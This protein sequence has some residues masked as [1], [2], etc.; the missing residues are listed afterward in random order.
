MRPLTSEMVIA[1][2][3]ITASALVSAQTPD[4]RAPVPVAA[5]SEVLGAFRTHQVVAISDPHGNVQQHAFIVSLL[6]APNFPEVVDDIVIETASARYQD[7][8]DRFI[9]GDEVPRATLRRAWLDHTVVNNGIGDQ[10]A[11][12]LDTVRSVNASLPA[13][14]RLRV[15]AGDPPIDWSNITSKDDHRRWIELRDS[16]P[17]DLI[18]RQVI[19]RGHH[20]L[21]IYGQGHLQRRQ[22]ASNYDMSVW[23]EQTL[24]SLLEH[25]TGIHVFNVWTLFERGVALP[26][27]VATWPVPALAIVR[28]TTLGAQDFGDYVQP[29]PRA[30]VQNGQLVPL[31]REQWKTMRMEDQF[32]AVLYLGPASSM[33][34]DAARP[35]L[36]NEPDL[37]AE[38][39][40]RLSTFGPPPELAAF[41][42]V[43]DVK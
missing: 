1:I 31:P 35:T 17:A 21:V 42:K 40:Q 25:D 14:R 2:V 5:V 10:T 29:R 33:T 3:A 41:K 22:I 39:I 38:R 4:T 23:Q 43:C 13:A 37:V 18:R 7:A 26:A 12:I 27:V 28:G 15:I 36:C 24:V 9:R 6:R 20:A 11:N 34:D 16:H 19:E 30:A 8:I 32:D